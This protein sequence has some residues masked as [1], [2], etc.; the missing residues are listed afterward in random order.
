LMKRLRRQRERRAVHLRRNRYGTN[1]KAGT[2]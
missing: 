2:L 1:E